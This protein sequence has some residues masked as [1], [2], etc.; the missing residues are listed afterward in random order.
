MFELK[1]RSD[2][3]DDVEMRNE[4]LNGIA[5]HRRKPVIPAHAGI[6]SICNMCQ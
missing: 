2:M 6:P 5:V 4:C 3:R 1:V